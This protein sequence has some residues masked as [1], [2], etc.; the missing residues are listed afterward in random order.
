MASRVHSIIHYWALV[1]SASVDVRICGCCVWIR[2]E[3]SVRVR[4]GVRISNR[5][6]RV[7]LVNYSLITALPIATPADPH[8][9]ILPVAFIIVRHC[10]RRSTPQ[11]SKQWSRLNFCNSY[12]GAPPPSSIRPFCSLDPLGLAQTL[13]EQLSLALSNQWTCYPKADEKTG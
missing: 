5:V 10:C 9:R 7:I 2:A 3:I 1:K 8:I 6:R 12:T 11:S 13:L 4:D